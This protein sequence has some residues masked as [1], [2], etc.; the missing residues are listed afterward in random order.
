[1]SCQRRLLPGGS[2]FY[3]GYIATDGGGSMVSCQE[4]FHLHGLAGAKVAAGSSGLSRLVRWIQFRELSD[5]LSW[6]QEG[7]ILLVSVHG[8]SE[9]RERWLPL[10]RGAVARNAAALL[11]CPDEAGFLLPSVALALA[12]R[13]K[14]PLILLPEKTDFADVLQQISAYIIAQQNLQHSV[15]SFFEQI[16]LGKASSA[17]QIFRQSM[18]YGYD[19]S[20]AQ[21][22]VLLHPVFL[23]GDGGVDERKD[24][25]LMEQQIRAFFIADERPILITLWMD[26]ILFLL[27]AEDVGDGENEAA[28]EQLLSGLRE[29]FPSLQHLAAG[30]GG[31]AESLFDLRESYL[32]A[33]KALSFSTSQIEDSVQS[34]EDLGIYK[35]LLEIPQAKLQIYCREIIGSLANCDRKYK[36]DLL[37]SLFVYFEENGNAVRTAQKLSV[38]RNTLEYRL[39]K[40]EEVSGKKLSNAYDRLLLQLAVLIACQLNVL[41]LPGQDLSL[42]KSS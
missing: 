26:H 36:L 38:H 34:Y 8:Q 40:V 2:L 15:G 21:Q 22:V 14:F 35:L 4:I 18:V 1:M 20:K 24:L 7:E 6:V 33:E 5:A 30:I 17:G 32:Q 13:E 23:H 25:C 31:R 28:L 42:T 19:F 29:R 12:E 41:S 10:L 3:M 37:H 39:K 9:G 27:S 11:I 16:L